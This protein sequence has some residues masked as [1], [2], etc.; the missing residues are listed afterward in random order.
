MLVEPVLRSQHLTNV[1][2]VLKDVNK[3]EQEQPIIVENLLAC[4]KNL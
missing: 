4:K 3:N 2:K 1:K